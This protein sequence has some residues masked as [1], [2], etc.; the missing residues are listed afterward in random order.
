MPQQQR[1]VAQGRA[2]GFVIGIL[3]SRPRSRLRSAA[4]CRNLPAFWPCRVLFCV[5]RSGARA[6]TNISHKSR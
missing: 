6:F 5:L 2:L 4:T 3:R 1:V